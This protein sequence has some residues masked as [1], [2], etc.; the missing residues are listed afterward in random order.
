MHCKCKLRRNPEKKKQ[1]KNNNNK[2]NKTK[3]NKTKQTNKQKPSIQYSYAPRTLCACYDQS[4]LT[5]HKIRDSSAR[6]SFLYNCT[7]NTLCARE[8]RRSCTRRIDSFVSRVIV[9]V[10][11]IR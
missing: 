11:N 7:Q 3:Q 5:I 4:E 6:A 2:K 1:T 10:A 9:F 8:H